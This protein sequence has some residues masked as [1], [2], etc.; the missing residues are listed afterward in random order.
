LYKQKASKLLQSSLLAK[1]KVGRKMSGI[2]KFT[3]YSQIRSLRQMVGDRLDANDF[4]GKDWND[5]WDVLQ[6]LECKLENMNLKED[7]EE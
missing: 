6:N 7:G 1:K 3:V 5:V 2:K 4:K